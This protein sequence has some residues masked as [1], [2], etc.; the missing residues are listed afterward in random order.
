MT[1]QK[2][3]I[4]KGP[5]VCRLLP[6]KAG[7]MTFLCILLVVMVSVLPAPAETGW[8]SKGNVSNEIIN[9]KITKSDWGNAAPADIGMLLSTV[10]RD[11]AVNFPDVKKEAVVVEYGGPATSFR[12]TAKGE[13]P[14]QIV[15]KGTYWGQFSYQFAHE[16]CH[17]MCM[18]TGEEKPEGAYRHLW[19]EE[20]FAECA[21]YFTM[22]KMAQT[23][24]TAPPYPGW[25]D[26]A[27]HLSNYVNQ[28]IEN[29]HKTEKIPEGQKFAQWFK[30]NEPLLATNQWGGVR[31]LNSIVAEQLLPLFEKNPA[32]WEAVVYARLKPA[33]SLSE[34]MNNWYYAVP[35]KY[36]AFVQEVMKNFDVKLLSPKELEKEVAGNKAGPPKVGR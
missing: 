22:R 7:M 16:L 28:T 9:L 10:I 17:A 25:K 33:N 20:S 26:Y 35:E 19:L 11:F 12:K 29:Y 24:K 34:L 27:P 14:I 15:C 30:S 5:F 13:R 6:G 8:D 23:W 4:E 21:S 31:A 3:Q 18:S 36:R 32:N 2:N 1:N